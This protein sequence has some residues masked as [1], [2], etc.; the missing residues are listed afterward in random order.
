MSLIRVRDLEI[1]QGSGI[2]VEHL[3]W[4]VKQGEHWVL[5]G[6]NG[7]GKTTLLSYLSAFLPAEEGQV[8]LFGE[9][10][11]AENQRAL[12]KRI[13]WVSGSFFGRYYHSETVLEIVLS[14]AGGML[15]ITGWVEDDRVRKAKALL[16][17]LNLSGKERYP[18]DLLSKGQQ[19]K[20]YVA[21][22]LMS[23]VEVLILDEP[24]SG[25]DLLARE[26]F[27]HLVETIAKEE[28][29]A[30][31]Y[32]THHTEEILPIFQKAA[33]MKD[34]NF[35]YTGDLKEVFRPEHLDSFFGVPTEVIW[36]DRHFFINLCMEWSQTQEESFGTKEEGNR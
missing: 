25:M 8:E 21:R 29:I 6:L 10:V 12:R 9:R 22:A 5:F 24:C 18:I 1:R 33:L 17:R 34:G 31:I 16:R 23:E 36:T 20:V 26:R 7:C 4:E 19:E 14:G 28:A 32:V 13:G 2:L 35:C 30:L 15:G 11:T 3:N 27:L